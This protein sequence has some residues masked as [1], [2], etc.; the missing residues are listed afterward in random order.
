MTPLATTRARRTLLAFVFLTLVYGSACS[1]TCALSACPRD[2][3]N[4]ST[5]DCD[6]NASLPAH[7]RTP[8]NPDCPKHHHP[9]FDAVK[10]DALSQSQ[11]TGANR[12]TAA[13]LLAVTLQN[14]AFALSSHSPF[15]DPAP[16]P[17]LNFA[18]YQKLSVLRI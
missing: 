2:A 4:A 1:T 10:T 8:Q 7:Q 14:E 6:H 16:A 17:D 11:L 13:Q 9:T 3:Q 15:S 12:A 18:I 5:H